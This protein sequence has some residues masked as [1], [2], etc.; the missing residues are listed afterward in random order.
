MEKC[1]NYSYCRRTQCRNVNAEWRLPNFKWSDG[2]ICFGSRNSIF[3]EAIWI[4]FC[5]TCVWQERSPPTA[6]SRLLFPIKSISRRHARIPESRRN[7]LPKV[8]G[9]KTGE[10]KSGKQIPEIPFNRNL[11]PRIHFAHFANLF[12]GAIYKRPVF[13]PPPLSFAP[14]RERGVTWKCSNDM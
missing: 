6:T 8:F 3:Y 7:Y 5:K 13:P 14:G 12:F 10:T 2:E 1:S 11:F 9:A 4:E